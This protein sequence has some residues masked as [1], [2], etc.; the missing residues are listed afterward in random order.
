MTASSPRS[1]RQRPSSTTGRSSGWRSRALNDLY[2]YVLNRGPTGNESLLFPETGEKDLMIKEGAKQELPPDDT[3]LVGNPVGDETFII[4]AS[5]KPLD[6]ANPAALFRFQQGRPAAG[7]AR[8]KAL[9]QKAVREKNLS[10]IQG[11]FVSGPEVGGD[12]HQG[13]AGPG[14]P[15]PAV[16]GHD[17]R[18]RRI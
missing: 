2:I 13:I 18:R 9:G 15:G 10:E 6:W 7:D 5:A 8:D 3:F 14:P 4:L 17:H 12:A 16:K 11:D 1:I